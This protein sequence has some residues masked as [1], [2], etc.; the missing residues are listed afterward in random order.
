MASQ[1]AVIYLD[2]AAATPLADDV[3]VAMQPYFSQ[4]FYNPSAS[5]KA[6]RAIRQALDMARAE[7]AGCLGAK[8]TE[9][10][11]TAGGT[12]AN[13]LAIRGIMDQF[14]EANLVISA[15]EHESILAPAE[16]YT[17]QL[18][19]VQP[20]G[21]VDLE[22]LQ[23][24][25]DE[26]TVLVSVMYANNEVGT[27]QPIREVAKLAQS[28]RKQRV[29]SGNKLPLYFHTDACQ[30]ANSLD[31]HVNRLGVDLMTLNGGK[32]YGP[33]QSGALFVKTGLVLKSQITGG[34]QERN[35]RSGTEQ[36]PAIIGLAKALVA[37]QSLRQAENERLDKLRNEFVNL[38]SES[39][40]SFVLNGS[41][42]YR[43]PGNVH[44]TIPGA[45]NELLLFGLDELGIQAAAGSACNASSDEPSHVLKAMGISDADARAS[46]RF[47]MG[48]TTSE[49]D[50]IKTVDAL[51]KPVSHL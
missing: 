34:G 36:V 30:A 19:P 5:Y 1:E 33:K 46:L 22:K 23:S 44:L 39:L 7:V 35:L 48:R 50:I 27:I 47:T 15:I 18:A 16:E 6:A 12:E 17:H 14:P 13:N 49:Q 45:D 8:S 25:I 38:L 11:F 26:H 51:K 32:I 3:L 43:L 29:E 42:K 40:P 20:D 37:A 9:I 2:H 28:I 21:R 4:L 24:C 41:L 31:L 10:I